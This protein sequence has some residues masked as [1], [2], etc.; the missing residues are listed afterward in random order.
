MRNHQN[1]LQH[2]EGFPSGL[3]NVVSEVSGAGLC[4]ETTRR[5]YYNLKFRIHWD[6]QRTRMEPTYAFLKGQKIDPCAIPSLG[7]GNSL[8]LSQHWAEHLLWLQH[9]R[10]CL[11]GPPNFVR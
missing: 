5:Y 3:P 4:F 1:L 7:L 10:H 2:V 9:Q 8:L 6:L 11:Q